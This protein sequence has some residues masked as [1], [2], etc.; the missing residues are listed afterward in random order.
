LILYLSVSEAYAPPFEFSG[1]IEKVVVE[2]ADDQHK[3]PDGELH[4]AMVGR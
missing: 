2:L 1:T 4:A 3:D